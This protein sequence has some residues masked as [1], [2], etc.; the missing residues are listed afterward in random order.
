MTIT[1]G[2]ISWDDNVNVGKNDKK[3]SNK[4]TWLRLKEGTNTVRLVTRP[5]QYLVHKGVKKVGDK[6]FGQKVN[7]SMANGSCPLCAK[8]HPTSPRW[9][10][11]VIDR[12]TNTYKILDVSS[13]IFFDIK[14]LNKNPKWGDPSKYDIDVIVD[15]KGGPQHYYTV[16]PNPHTPLSASDQKIRDEQVDLDELKRRVTPPTPEQAQT[17]L[18][19]LLD[20]GSLFI[21]EPQEK[22]DNGGKSV[23]TAKAKSAPVVDMS[24][25]SVADIFPPYAGNEAETETA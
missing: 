12:E 20:G 11:G 24:E 7:C 4:D 14:G 9:F 2:E 3:S 13:G 8:G 1:H 17:R 5:H 25:D 16:Q 21:P 19:K 6:G 18:D 23:K 22:S 10:L 15:K